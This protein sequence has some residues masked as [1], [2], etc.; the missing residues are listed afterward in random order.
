VPD[1][2]YYKNGWITL[3]VSNYKLLCEFFF[4][5]KPPFESL[6]VERVCEAEPTIP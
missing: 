6:T 5:V 4:I 2:Y 3:K 1:Y